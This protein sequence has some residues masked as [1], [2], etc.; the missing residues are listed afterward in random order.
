ML[1]D[2]WVD[3]NCEINSIR[4]EKKYSFCMWLKLS[5]Y[6]L[7]IQYNILCK[8]HGSQQTYL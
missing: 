7:N 2:M 5:S 4:Y 3:I 1:I 6:Q 8:A